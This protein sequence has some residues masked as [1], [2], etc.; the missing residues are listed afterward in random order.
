MKS[1]YHMC[2][3]QILK[4]LSDFQSHIKTVGYRQ[5]GLEVMELGEQTSGQTA[6]QRPS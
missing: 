3:F 5:W 4:E 6:S 2:S 1:P